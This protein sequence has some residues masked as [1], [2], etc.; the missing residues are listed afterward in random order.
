MLKLKHQNIAGSII[1]VTTTSTLWSDLVNTA[2][3]TSLRNAGFDF[4]ANGVDIIPLDGDIRFQEDG[5]A[6]TATEGQPLDQNHIYQGRNTS[7]DNLR[8]IC[9]SGTVTCYIQPGVCNNYESSSIAAAGASS[10]SGDNSDLISNTV[11]HES[12][13][14]TTANTEYTYTLPA[15][16]KGFEMRLDVNSSED[17]KLNYNGSAGDSATDYITIE[18][19]EMYW[20]G[21]LAL[22]AG[23]VLRFQSPT[24][25]QTMKIVTYS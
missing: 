10:G 11:V 14:M 23:F 20:R 1:T 2:A 22:P 15:S 25:A 4:K 13:T 16:I 24:A 7:L 6:P 18:D 9:A 21:T 17:F 12:V 3:G 5:N 19:G 8:L